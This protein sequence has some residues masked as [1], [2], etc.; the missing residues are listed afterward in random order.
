MGD[1]EWNQEAPYNNAC[2]VIDGVHCPT[3]CVAT[4]FAQ[5]MKYYN[6]PSATIKRIPAYRSSSGFVAQYEKG[7][8]I[9]W[10]DIR[11]FYSPNGNNYTS[12]EADA[13][14]QH[15]AMVGAACEM[16]YNI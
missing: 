9:N 15:C 10:Q 12:K 4:A 8:P 11:D 16:N 6:Y 5:V 1:I 3:G 14:A 13:V 7:T 2:P